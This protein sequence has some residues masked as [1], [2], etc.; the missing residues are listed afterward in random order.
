MARPK[1]KGLSYFPMDTRFLSDDKVCTLLADQG[2]A[3]LLAVLSLWGRMYE[4]E[5]PIDFNKVVKVGVCKECNLAT[6]EL[7]AYVQAAIET[8]LLELTDGKLFSNGV[9]SRIAE[10]TKD[11]DR[12]RGSRCDITESPNKS[13]QTANKLEQTT[14]TFERSDEQTANS[15]SLSLYNLSLDQEEEGTGEETK[16]ELK[17]VPLPAP[18]SKPYGQSRTVL[19][20]DE[21]AAR[22]TNFYTGKGLTI[23]DFT[24]GVEVLDGWKLD[25][26]K[27]AAGRRSDARM[28]T[29][30]VYRTVVEEKTAEARLKRSTAPPQFVSAVSPPQKRKE[31]EQFKALDLPRVSEQERRENL[32]KLETLLTSVR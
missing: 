28:L 8:G 17:V 30:W 29:G 5:G 23:E 21:E 2:H 9:A 7:E 13:E 19:L 15:L 1:K 4:A 22:V 16:P 20:T 24:R 3:A 32:K 31:H 10:V 26:P 18:K 14:N 12:M 6:N 27:K 11:R 25:N